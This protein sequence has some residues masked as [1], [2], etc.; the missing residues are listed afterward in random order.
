MWKFQDFSATQIREIKFGHFE[1]TN[2][3]I[4]TIL[5]FEFLRTFDIVKC[6]I[7]P[8]MKIQSHKNCKN[9]GF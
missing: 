7:F 6:E 5:N 4:L 1:A 9:A 3:A 8:K 2:I